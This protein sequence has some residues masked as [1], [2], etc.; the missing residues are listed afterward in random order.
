[1]NMNKKPQ[2]VERRLVSEPVDG[3][4]T[5]EHGG[6]SN[7]A[8]ALFE[9]LRVGCITVQPLTAPAFTCFSNRKECSWLTD[10]PMTRQAR[11]SE[12]HE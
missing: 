4:C 6:R 11:M 8:V 2:R 3:G 9:N 5:L 12:L 7:R 1:M 10:Q